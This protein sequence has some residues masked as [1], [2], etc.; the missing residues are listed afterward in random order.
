MVMPALPVAARLRE[1]ERAVAEPLPEVQLVLS[2]HPMAQSPQPPQISQIAVA[3]LGEPVQVLALQ[4][5]PELPG[6]Q[7]SP[8]QALRVSQQA[9]P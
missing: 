6:R 5:Q 8:K 3:R 9:L 4:Q 2:K 7:R 1:P